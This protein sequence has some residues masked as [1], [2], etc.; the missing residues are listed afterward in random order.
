[1]WRIGLPAR[2]RHGDIVCGDAAGVRFAHARL[3]DTN[4]K[5]QRG[6][7]GVSR[8]RGDGSDRDVI[9]TRPVGGWF[10]QA[11]GE[12]LREHFSELTEEARQVIAGH[13][14]YSHAK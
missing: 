2:R 1:M 3:A 14:S 8:D 9:Y 6:D 11:V 12:G 10:D 5:P 4:K 13:C 7:A